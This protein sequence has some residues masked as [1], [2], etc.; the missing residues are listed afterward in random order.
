MLRANIYTK[1][2][3]TIKHCYKTARETT[4]NSNQQAAIKIINVNK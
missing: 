2:Q 3:S 1:E 4:E